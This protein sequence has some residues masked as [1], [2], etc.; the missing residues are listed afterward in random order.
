MLLHNILRELHFASLS[1]VSKCFQGAT[2][3]DPFPLRVHEMDLCFTVNKTTGYEA[4]QSPLFYV[5][6]TVL[7]LSRAQATTGFEFCMSS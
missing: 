4:L 7:S 5:F 1:L 6:V 3:S 2:S